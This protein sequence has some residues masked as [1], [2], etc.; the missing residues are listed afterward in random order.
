MKWNSSIIDLRFTRR[1]RFPAFVDPHPLVGKLPD[2]FLDLGGEGGGRLYDIASSIA[3]FRRVNHPAVHRHIAFLL[4]IPRAAHD[5][6]SGICPHRKKRS[7]TGR[8]GRQAEKGNEYTFLWMSV[9]VRQNAEL[10][11][12][13]KRAGRGHERMRLVDRTVSQL[14]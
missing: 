12:S 13:T 1:T 11:F 6:Y 7:T 3:G 10:A 14:G 8:T 4:F 2:E 9:H 5:Q